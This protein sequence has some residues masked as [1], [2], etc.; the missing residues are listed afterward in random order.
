MDFTMSDLV[1]LYHRQPFAEVT[2]NNQTKFVRYKSPN[3]ILPSLQGFFNHV[4]TG[5]W[6]AW[7]EE[8]PGETFEPILPAPN[9]GNYSI[10]RIG[11]NAEEIHEFYHVT[12]KEVFWPLLHSFPEY[13]STERANWNNFVKVNK[14]FAMAAAEEASDESIIWVHDYNL[15]MAPYWIRQYKPKAKIAFFHHTP[16]PAADIFNILPWRRE[17]IE[18]LLACNLIGF[19]IPR[20]AENFVHTAMNFEDVQ[21]GERRAVGDAFSTHGPALSEPEMTTSLFYKGRKIIV[22]AFPVGCDPKGIAAIQETPEHSDT[23]ATIRHELRDRKMLFSVG[24]IDYVKGILELLHAYERLLEHRSE[25]HKKIQL[26]LGCVPAAKGMEIYQETQAD[27]ERTVGA[28]NGRFARVD[29]I[30]INLFARAIPF[31]ELIAYYE[32]TDICLITPLRDGLN[33]VAKEYIAVRGGASGV[34]VLSEFTGAAVELPEAI[35]TN[36]YAVDEMDRA[37][38]MAVDMSEE[39]ACQRMKDLDNHIKK[40]TVGRWSEHLLEQFEQLSGSIWQKQAVG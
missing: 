26:I 10:R 2:E 34:L 8:K 32:C 39:E 31:E 1:I 19:H 29:W 23:V 25:L 13:H 7:K 17:I 36:P 33:L 12:S 18:S 4:H 22:D 40:Y 28:I 14:Q 20:Y 37:L 3:G 30:P 21:L 38:E 27:I 35:L 5:T 16:F 6:I 15:W 24:R 11:L 9:N